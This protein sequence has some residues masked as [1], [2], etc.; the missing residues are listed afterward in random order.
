[1]QTI[2]QIVNT[3]KINIQDIEN[4]DLSKLD[5]LKN[6]IDESK[7][8][9]SQLS[10]IIKSKNC[11]SNK[12]EEI[13]FFK[14][15]KPFISG[16]LKFFAKLQ[17]FQM[18]RPKA[19]DQKQEKYI[20][21]TIKKLENHKKKNLHFWKYVRRRQ[22]SLDKLYFLRRNN[23][24]EFIYDI[25]QYF[26]DPDFSTSHDNLMAHVVAFDLL[27]NHYTYLLVKQSLN[28][29]DLKLITQSTTNKNQFLWKGSKTDLIELIYALYSLGVIGNSKGELSKIFKVCESLF[30]IK[31]GNP[32]KTFAEIKARVDGQT[33][34]IDRL[35][36]SLLTKINLDVS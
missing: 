14:Y 17:Q 24:L 22:T 15:T 12:E 8:T 23:N 1:M 6:G 30:N 34:F 7:N 27:T 19:D 21:Q 13:Y 29:A 32:Y 28:Q 9:L 26:F 16:R 18:E 36:E 4:E 25:S 10:V 20:R 11:F 3:Y 5:I 2:S 31:L 35:K 33:K